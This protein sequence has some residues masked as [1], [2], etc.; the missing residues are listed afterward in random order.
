MKKILILSVTAGDG[1]NAIGNAVKE[2][3]LSL[4]YVVEF[5]D[6]IKQY[7]TK[8]AFNKFDKGY[9]FV[10]QYFIGIYNF[11]YKIL[12]KKNPKHWHKVTG[13]KIVKNITPKLYNELLKFKPDAVICTHVYAA[14]AMSNLHRTFNLPCQ[15]F[16]ILTDYMV[17]P[18]WEAATKINYLLLPSSST[19]S[20]ALHKGFIKNQ[21]IVTGIPVSEKHLQFESKESARQFLQLQQ[22]VFT[23]LLIFSKARFKN[24]KKMVMHILKTNKNIQLIIVNGKNEKYKK[25]IDKLILKNNYINVLNLAYVNY[26]HT[27]ISASDVVVSKAGVATVNETLNKNVPLLVYCKVAEQENANVNY[28]VKNNASFKIKNLNHLCSVINNCSTDQSF[29]N[30]LQSNIIKIKKPNACNDIVN[31]IKNTETN[32]LNSYSSLPKYEFKT[33]KNK[34]KWAIKKDVAKERK[35]KEKNKTK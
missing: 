12:S 5:I 34:I 30:D 21:L 1:H 24:I 22:N 2:K 17:H 28:L 26:L 29:L 9:L 33:I 18:F 23:I 11:V 16:G 15:T 4:G 14:I 32:Y 31:L 6:I 19:I 20:T 8:T 25:I 35:K 10:C 3:L 7:S 27:C 13:Q